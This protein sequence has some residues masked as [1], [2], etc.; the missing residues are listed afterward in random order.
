LIIEIEEML[1]LGDGLE[2][3]ESSSQELDFKDLRRKAS[4]ILKKLS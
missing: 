3:A 4:E 1:R 2:F